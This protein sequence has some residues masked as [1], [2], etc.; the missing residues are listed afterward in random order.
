MYSYLLHAFWHLI[1]INL[2]Y[3]MSFHHMSC[4]CV[5]LCAGLTL[6]LFSYWYEM[7]VIEGEALLKW[8]EDMSHEYPGKGQ[9]LFQ[10]SMDN[11]CTYCHLID[12][13]LLC[14]IYL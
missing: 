10:V 2:Q 6:R 11:Y 13:Y 14:F 5:S 12:S 9:T 1:H 4:S 3:C 7:D 8:K